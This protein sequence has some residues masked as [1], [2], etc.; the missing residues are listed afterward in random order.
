MRDMKGT[1][2]ESLPALS[3]RSCRGAGGGLLV[4]I[5]PIARDETSPRRVSSSL[6]SLGS[7]AHQIA[8]SQ[9]ESHLTLTL[10]EQAFVSAICS[11]LAPRYSWDGCLSALLGR[12]W[13]GEAA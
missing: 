4:L 9:F 2:D 5:C 6:A 7:R 13:K 8:L 3:G 12:P 10:R 1:G 11:L